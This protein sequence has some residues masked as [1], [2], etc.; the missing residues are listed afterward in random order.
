[1]IISFIVRYVIAFVNTNVLRLKQR[2]ASYGVVMNCF[3]F[4]FPKQGGR[5]GFFYTFSKTNVCRLPTDIY[6][7]ESSINDSKKIWQ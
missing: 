1:M 6:I 4:L 2:K 7:V 5:N 3:S